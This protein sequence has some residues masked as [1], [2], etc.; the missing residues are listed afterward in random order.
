MHYE[1]T[2]AKFSY[3]TKNPLMNLFHKFLHAKSLAESLDN[4][5][6][7]LCAAKSFRRSEATQLVQAGVSS[8]G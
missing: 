3:N 4:P 7:N 2:H 6:K 8:V 1:I 5:K